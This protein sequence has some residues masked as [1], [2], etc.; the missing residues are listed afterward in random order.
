MRE[1]LVAQTQGLCDTPLPMHVDLPGRAEVHVKSSYRSGGEFFVLKV[2]CTFPANLPL[3][4][5]VGNGMVLLFSAGTGEPVVYFADQGRMTDIRTAAVAAMTARELGRRDQDIGILGTGIQARCQAQLQSRVLDLKSIWVWG[6]TP[7]RVEEFRKDL[8]GMLPAVEVKT[9]SS[10]AQVAANA[11]LIITTTA[12]RSP[13]LQRGDIRPGTCILAVGADSPGKRE[14]A[15]EI[16]QD[17]GLLLV[18]SLAQCRRLGELQH[19]PELA[20]K[21]VEIGAYC[22]S[23][24]PVGED[25]IT[26]ADFTGLGVED[27]YI[28]QHCY[29]M[30]QL[31]SAS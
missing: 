13:L 30:M 10:P 20:D 2:A 8:A 9:A 6:R 23:P 7:Q 19:C 26:V 24:C 12:S 28:A 14:L 16:L 4:L 29:R 5:P 3:G 1:A 15:P 27:L 22:L 25:E 31:G 11:R 21:A 17:A 18:D